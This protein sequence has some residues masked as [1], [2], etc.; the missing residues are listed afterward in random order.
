MDKERLIKYCKD[1]EI[2]LTIDEN[3]SPEKLARLKKSA[4]K[5]IRFMGG[6]R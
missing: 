2:K 1:H 4:D 3:P 6:S 5:L